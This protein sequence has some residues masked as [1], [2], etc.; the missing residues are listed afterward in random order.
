M[1]ALL[2]KLRQLKAKAS[3][4]PWG[5]DTQENDGAY[6]SGPGARHGFASTVI[7]D[8]NG[9]RLF[10]ALNS[11]AAEIHEES[12]G[13][14]SGTWVNAWDDVSN[15][16]GALIEFLSEHAEAMFAEAAAECRETM[17]RFVEQGGDAVTANSIRQNWNPE[18]GADPTKREG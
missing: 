11:D 15:R 4:G 2:T 8:A 12:D 17:A 3:P 5:T 16:N 18:W 10:D 1:G 7:L 9:K 14:E 6:G 13:D